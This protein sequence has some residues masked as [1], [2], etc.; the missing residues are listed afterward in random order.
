MGTAKQRISGVAI[1]VR[2]YDEAKNYYENVLGFE[3]VADTPM[4]EG[5]RWIAVRPPGSEMQLV[6]AKASSQEQLSRVGNQT[7]GRVFLFLH[8]DNFQRDYAAYRERGVMF[9]ELPREEVYGTVAVF[10]DLYGNLWD[11]IE[12][13]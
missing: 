9:R 8:T 4:G 13:R 1:V 6:L 5:K 11:L 12:R 3:V 2:D 7:G 10:Q